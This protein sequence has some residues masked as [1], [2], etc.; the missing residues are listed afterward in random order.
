MYIFSRQRTINPR[1]PDKSIGAALEIGEMVT[2]LTGTH[3]NVWLNQ[4]AP[5]GHSISWSVRIENQAELDASL[6]KLMGS[7]AYADKVE[8]LADLFLGT[9]TDQLVQIVAGAGS[10]SPAPLVSIVSAQAA[11]GHQ[12]EALAWGADLATKVAHA[13][14]V[15][16]AF[17]VGVYG[18][19]GSVGWISGYDDAQQLDAAREKLAADASLQ[20]AIDEGGHLVQSEANTLLL[21]RLN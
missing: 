15:S 8:E 10:D 16:V 5:G 6:G 21:R 3:V 1:R 17:G 4:F 11:N 13:L 19:Y 20:A 7:A 14:D 18:P 9:S 2:E 12:R